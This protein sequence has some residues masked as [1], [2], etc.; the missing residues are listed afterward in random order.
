MS[1][2]SVFVTVLC[3]YVIHPSKGFDMS[4]CFWPVCLRQMS[5]VSTFAECSS[6]KPPIH[7]KRC[8]LIALDKSVGVSASE[9]NS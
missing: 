3:R 5:F 6:F 9:V 2:K 4:N 8:V 7:C 1:I